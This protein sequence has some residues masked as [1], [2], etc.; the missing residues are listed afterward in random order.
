MSDLF[1]TQEEEELAGQTVEQ[2]TAP[3]SHW[4]S[5]VCEC[6]KKIGAH[7]S[8]YEILVCHCD[9]KFWALRPKRFR[10]LVLFPWPSCWQEGVRL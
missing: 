10:P 9:R 3:Q 8:H 1:L 2:P 6:G 5:V 4:V 7:L